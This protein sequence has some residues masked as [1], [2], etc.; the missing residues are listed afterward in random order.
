MQTILQKYFD[1]LCHCILHATY[2][3]LAATIASYALCSAKR[4]FASTRER[5]C[6]STARSKVHSAMFI[7]RMLPAS[8]CCDSSSRRAVDLHC[9]LRSKSYTP[10]FCT[11]RISFFDGKSTASLCGGKCMA[12]RTGCSSCRALFARCLLSIH[13]LISLSG[14][15]RQSC[16]PYGKKTRRFWVMLCAAKD[17]T[18]VDIMG[19][20]FCCNI[21]RKSRLWQIWLVRRLTPDVAT[22]YEW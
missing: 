10:L 14:W 20:M 12:A 18:S 13:F 6:N 5:S 22:V 16:A 7:I 8:N 21:L 2:S 3:F 9:W 4:Q 15:I 19:R 1:F 17:E 11:I